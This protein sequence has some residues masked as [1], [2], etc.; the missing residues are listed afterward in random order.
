MSSNLVRPVLRGEIS[1]DYVEPCF[2][3]KEAGVWVQKVGT[4]SKLNSYFICGL[5]EERHRV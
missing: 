2:F 1:V 4:N 3:V 5:R